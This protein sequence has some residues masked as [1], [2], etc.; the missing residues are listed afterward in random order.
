MSSINKCSS[1]V[2]FTG[3]LLAVPLSLSV[4]LCPSL[5]LPSDPHL[6]SSSLASLSTLSQCLH[7][8]KTSLAQSP[9]PAYI[10]LR[11]WQA[12]FLSFSILISRFYPLS[13]SSHHPL[14]L[15]GAR[16]Y[17]INCQTIHRAI[18]PSPLSGLFDKT[19]G[20]IGRWK[21]AERN[22]EKRNCWAETPALCTQ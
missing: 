17:L 13:S 6:Y 2:R 9:Q 15:S 19:C 4:P 7:R 18:P 11:R 1:P 8:H 20:S 10:S 5:S 16:L 3:V 12:L 22:G 21:R 14:F